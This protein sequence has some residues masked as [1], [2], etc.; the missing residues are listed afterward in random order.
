[1]I[2][3]CHDEYLSALLKYHEK[4]KMEFIYSILCYKHEI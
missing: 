3:A 1:M 2:P 4:N